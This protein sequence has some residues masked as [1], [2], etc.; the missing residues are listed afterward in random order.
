M[1]RTLTAALAAVAL[2]LPIAAA[3]AAQ[4]K[5]LPGEKVTITATVEAIDHA[6]RTLTLKGPKGN[7]VDV[8]VPEDVKRFNEVKV[9]DT[10]TSTYYENI[11]LTVQRPGEKPK[12][13][14]SAG[15]T[16]GSGPKPVATA[17]RQRTI[18]AV[19]D[20][21][22]PKVPSISFKGPK[23]WRYSSRVEDKEALKKVK[24]GD[25]VDITW[26]EALL[27]SFEAPKR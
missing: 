18:T 27:V 8:V 1:T 4:T 15:I 3:A 19:I 17:S 6:A 21:I 2:T 9:G 24:V 16:P 12:D 20:E 25:K 10:L 23:G 22:D 7:Y 26:T 13:T 5:V 11:V 14:A